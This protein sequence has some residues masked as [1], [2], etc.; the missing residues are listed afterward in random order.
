MAHLSESTSRQQCNCPCAFI[1]TSLQ[2]GA[3]YARIAR[4][5]LPKE[6]DSRRIR[7][8]ARRHT[9]LCELSSGRHHRDPESERLEAGRTHS[10]HK[11]RGWHGLGAFGY[12]FR[13]IRH[14]LTQVVSA[15]LTLP[16][17]G[18][19]AR[20]PGGMTGNETLFLPRD[21]VRTPL[22]SFRLFMTRRA[23]RSGIDEEYRIRSGQDRLTWQPKTRARSA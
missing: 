21:H 13:G 14:T 23:C 7:A 16:D 10:A 4:H 1:V 20:Y 8:G 15:G 22:A 19:V 18:R 5:S 9:R 6:V 17:C 2:G 12:K 11:G 3:G